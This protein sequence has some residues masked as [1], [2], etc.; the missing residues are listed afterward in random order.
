MAASVLLPYS[1]YRAIYPSAIEQYQQCARRFY[2]QRVERHPTINQSSPAMAK[3]N[4]A[5]SVLKACGEHLKRTGG[6][7]TDIR[8][9]V[10]VELA[11]HPE[12]SEGWRDGDIA[13]LT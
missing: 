10:S 12:L 9:L 4:A 7:P 6:F 5:H 11:R 3:G 1:P 13:E 2:F 8:Q